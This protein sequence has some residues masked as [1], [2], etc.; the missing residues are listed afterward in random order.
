MKNK[1]G[2]YTL[3]SKIEVSLLWILFNIFKFKI[4]NLEG[5]FGSYDY[6]GEVV[7]NPYK[8]LSSHYNYI[9]VKNKN[10]GVK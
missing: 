7:L 2:T 3:R 8:D 10:I 6:I 4:G 9:D 1:Y 5:I